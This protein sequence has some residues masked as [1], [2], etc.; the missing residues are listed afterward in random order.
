[1]ALVDQLNATT[2]KFYWPSVVSQVVTSTPFLTRLIKRKKTRGDGTKFRWS[3]VHMLNSGQWYSGYELLDVTP[4][5][6]IAEA[7]L[8]WVNHHIP[9]SISGD[10]IDKNQGE[11][12]IHDLL[13]EKMKLAKQAATYYLGS[14]IWTGTSATKKPTGIYT[15]VAETPTSGTY[16]NIVRGTDDT[17]SGDFTDWW[18]NQYHDGSNAAPTLADMEIVFNNCERGEYQPT[19]IVTSRQG[20]AKY[21]QIAQPYQRIPHDDVSALGFKSLTFNGIPV[22]KDDQCY[23]DSTNSASNFYFLHEP[24]L[25]LRFITGKF[26]DRTDWVVPRD[27]D[28]MTCSIR[29]K[30]VFA[31]KTPKVHGVYHSCL[32][33]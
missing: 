12:R 18:Q 4:I 2:N 25:E 1:M 17:G 7:E 27:Q 6:Q 10:E 14:G 24:D 33:T 5:D 29:N 26:M 28:A 21:W 19:I 20:Y 13:A 23:R 31:V 11:E 9:L 22:V 16:A 32:D 3:V 8:D 15:A 30:L